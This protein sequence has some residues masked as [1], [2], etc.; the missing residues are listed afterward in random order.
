MCDRASIALYTGCAFAI[1][2]IYVYIEKIECADGARQW[3]I[4]GPGRDTGPCSAA[5]PALRAPANAKGD[6]GA[7]ATAQT[8]DSQQRAGPHFYYAT[9]TFE[10]T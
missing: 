3:Q 5:S 4:N 10:R 6:P 9:F 8:A 1:R 2:P 7:P